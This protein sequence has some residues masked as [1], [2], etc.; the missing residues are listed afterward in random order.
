M[1]ECSYCGESFEGEQPYLR[2]LDEHHRDELGSIDRRRV[3][4]DLDDGGSGLPTG[5]LVLGFV[6][7]VAAGL[8]AYVVFFLGGSS[9]AT[10]SDGAGVDGPAS[11]D[12][13]AQS[14]GSVGSAH[15]HGT[16]QVVIDGR[17]VD[18]SQQRYQLRADAFHFENG[19]GQVWHKHATGVTL[20][21]AMATLDIGV[22]EDTVVFD[23]R[24]Y[25][26]SDPGT[27]VTVTVN[28]EPVDPQTYVLEGAPD[29]NPERGDSVRI[30]AETSG[31]E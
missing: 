26:E 19:N 21:W 18:F 6:L 10:G 30:V 25:R 8:V 14:P 17:E 3:E 15:E 20:E 28:G 29:T 5:P 1:P 23:G 24:V 4:E 11:L 7:L 9:P 13:V 22:S 27:N 2:H 16:L 31:S 12:S